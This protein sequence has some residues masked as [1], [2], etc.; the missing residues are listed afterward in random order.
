[1]WDLIVS[2]PD[3]CLS[4]YLVPML[5][6]KNKKKKKKNDEKMYLFSRWVVRSAVII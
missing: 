5:E 3:H 1:M 2:V 6:Q 4:F